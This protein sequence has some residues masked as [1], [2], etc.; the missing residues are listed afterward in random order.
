MAINI[1]GINPPQSSHARGKDKVQG[2]PNESPASSGVSAKV[3][4][5][6]Q[7]E[8]SRQAKTLQELEAK[9]AGYPEVN[10]QKV[11]ILRKA[12]REGTYQVD[13]AR[14]AAKIVK[15]ELDI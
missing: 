1:N 2:T 13:P 3:D 12:L 8:L 14:L 7:V 11:Q 10:Q 15:Y 4:G 6:D 5:T 9:L